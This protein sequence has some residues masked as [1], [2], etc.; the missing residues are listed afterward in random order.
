MKKLTMEQKRELVA[1]VDK[2]VRESGETIYNVCA[3]QGVKPYQYYNW[4]RRIIQLDAQL[5]AK[6]A[7][8]AHRKGVIVRKPVAQEVPAAASPIAPATFS[9]ARPKNLSQVYEALKAKEK[10]YSEL[11]DQVAKVL[12]DK[13]I[14]ELG[15]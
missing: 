14:A 4:S 3:K 5:R 12:S 6:E 7:R 13:T 1:G 11:A 2:E 15:L 8:R 9:T 10:H